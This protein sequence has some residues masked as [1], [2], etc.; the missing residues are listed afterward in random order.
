MNCAELGTSAAAGSG[1]GALLSLPAA[2]P[3]SCLH[4][5]PGVQRARTGAKL[6]PDAQQLCPPGN[7]PGLEEGVQPGAAPQ[8][9]GAAW[10]AASLR[11]L[12]F[13]E[14][15]GRAQPRMPRE[16]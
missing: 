9:A 8:G 6:S 16:K 11:V 1:E 4:P 2:Q 12:G 10:G 14:L 13:T 15:R 5:P 3:W 7:A